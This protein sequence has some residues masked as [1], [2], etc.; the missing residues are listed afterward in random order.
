MHRARPMFFCLGQLCMVWVVSCLLRVNFVVHIFQSKKHFLNPG[1]LS[2]NRL[3]GNGG[4]IKYD[5]V[6]SRPSYPCW[7]RYGVLV[8]TCN[9]RTFKHSSHLVCP[10]FCG[11]MRTRVYQRRGFA[12]V[13]SSLLRG[14]PLENKSSNIMEHIF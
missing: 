3:S 7:L 11:C 5:P 14:R 12:C 13:A 10:A 9:D 2:S 1:P 8:R 4:L 6:L